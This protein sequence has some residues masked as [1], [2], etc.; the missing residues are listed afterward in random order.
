MS[1]I[2]RDFS[3]EL[4]DVRTFL[5]EAGWSHENTGGKFDYYT[6][7]QELGIAERYRIA[8]PLD[9]D[10]PGTDVLVNQ[11]LAALQQLYGFRFTDLLGRVASKAEVLGAARLNIR[12]VDPET[13]SG[14]IPLVALRVFLDQIQKGFYRGAKFKIDGS[15]HGPQNTAAEAF[16]QE[17]KFLQTCEGSFIARVEV[18]FTLLVQADLFGR[19]QITSH[20]VC[21]HIISGIEFINDRVLN[22]NDDLE[23]DQALGEAIT[24]FDPELLEVFSKMLVGPEAEMI[25]MAMQIGEQNRQSS[26]G[27]IT[28]E[29]RKRLGGFVRYFK[30]HFYNEDAID[31]LGQVVE[32]R[33]RDPEGNKNHIR[34]VADFFGDR[35][36]FSIPLTNDQYQLA[37]DAHRNKLSVR[38][39][40]SGTRLKTQVRLNAVREFVIA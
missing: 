34:V 7:P 18:P 2:R 10:R 27:R 11:A 38:V 36:Y 9:P 8:L 40:G 15:S 23:S 37:V 22:G 14:A 19:E 39:R 13:A 16:V 3:Q 28:D 6:P 33:S 21:A 35:S 30:E 4:M 31:I 1:R 26:T 12:F 24:L 17:S 32:L 25:E 20:D 5:L 29:K